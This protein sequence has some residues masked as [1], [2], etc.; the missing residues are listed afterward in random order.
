MR[1]AEIW[2]YPVKSMIGERVHRARLTPLG[3]AGD[4]NW[5]VRDDER[6]GI[7]GAKKIAELMLFAAETQ[8]D[9]SV[10]ITLPDGGTVST[11]DADRDQ[12]ISAALEHEVALVAL[13]PPD[14]LDH[15]R[16]G[17][18]DSDDPLV[19]LREI[20]GRDEDE[21]FPDL[22][23][24]PP[25]I[26]EFESPLGT[27]HDAFP[28]LI[29]T[30]SALR[31]MAVALPESVIDIRRFRP[32]IVVDTGLAPGNPEFDW[33]GQRIRIGDAVLEIPAPCPRC[34][35]VTREVTPEIPADRA[36]LRHIIQELDQNLGV[37][38]NVTTPGTISE[39]DELVLLD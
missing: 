14:D 16:R 28:L 37:Y 13:A 4:R 27:H 33:V 18:P 24:F 39:R 30:S 7:R 29:L 20:F 17:A 10:L 26:M 25:E 22:S 31:A 5:A 1:V 15:Y 12:R 2:N 3:I 8:P 34:V 9:G 23:I 32:S 6:G 38:A 36:V 35:M 19:E 21:P 11:A